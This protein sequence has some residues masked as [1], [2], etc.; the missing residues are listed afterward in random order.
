LKWG[1]KVLTPVESTEYS[2]E[3]TLVH[4]Q[5]YPIS[6]PMF[7][8]GQVSRLKAR[9]SPISQLVIIVMQ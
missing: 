6:L 1:V 4:T 9:C 8:I 7:E 3:T 2:Q 5:E